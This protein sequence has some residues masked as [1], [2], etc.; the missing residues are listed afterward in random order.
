MR[1]PDVEQSQFTWVRVP[2]LI[3]AGTR[4]AVVQGVDELAA[5]L[6]NGWVITLEG[7]THLDA[8]SDPQ[9]KRA[10]LEFFAAA[11]S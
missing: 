8:L 4:D 5:S 3:A 1:R 11:T 10:A 2:V 6:P 7:R 9:F